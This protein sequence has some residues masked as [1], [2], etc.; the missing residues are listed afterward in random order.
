M[1]DDRREEVAAEEHS[2]ELVSVIGF[3]GVN[4]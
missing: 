4:I 3:G 2:L 1:E